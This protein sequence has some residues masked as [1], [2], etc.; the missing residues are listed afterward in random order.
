M[1]IVAVLGE[2][3]RT[4]R[5]GVSVSDSLNILTLSMTYA[6]RRRAVTSGLRRRMLACV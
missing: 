4:L 2:D 3:I 1:I 6:H 5:A